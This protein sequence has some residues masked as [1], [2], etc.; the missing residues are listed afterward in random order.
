[1]KTPQE[2]LSFDEISQLSPEEVASSRQLQKYIYHALI[3]STRDPTIAEKGA[4]ESIQLN[5]TPTVELKEIFG[6]AYIIPGKNTFRLN[7][8]NIYLIPEE[9]PVAEVPDFLRDED[10]IP[11]GLYSPFKEI[12]FNKLLNKITR[13][14]AFNGI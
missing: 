6:D 8:D 11:S 14:D 2:I 13:K 7:D 5:P 3:D 12:Q 9:W 1:M 10:I 4:D